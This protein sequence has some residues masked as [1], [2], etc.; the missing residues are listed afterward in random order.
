MHFG[1]DPRFDNLRAAQVRLPASTGTPRRGRS[2]GACYL[3]PA[4]DAAR[5]AGTIDDSFVSALVDQVSEGFG[6]HVEVCPRVFLREL[7]DVLDRV[8]QFADFDPRSHY[9]LSIDDDALRPEEVAAR[10]GRSPG[11]DEEPVVPKR[12]DG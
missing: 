8:D 3:F 7:V 10:H 4:R 12:L 9:K 6:G 1:D 2:T 11:A 5:V